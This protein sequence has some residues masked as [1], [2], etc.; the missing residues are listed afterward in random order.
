M[1]LPVLV[2]DEN[3]PLYI[4]FD[5]YFC[6][7]LYR[8]GK[9]RINSQR[10]PRFPLDPSFFVSYRC[11]WWFKRPS[12]QIITGLLMVF[13]QDYWWSITGLLMVY[14][15]CWW[16]FS[17]RCWWWFIIGFWL[18]LSISIVWSFKLIFGI[19]FSRVSFVAV[20][21]YVVS[22]SPPRHKPFFHASLQ[23]LNYYILSKR[24]MS[25]I[26]RNELLS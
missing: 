15:R 10:K 16:W 20:D 13:I 5:Y 25:H 2:N 18:F 4:L 12:V 23:T 17:Y 6:F 1:F 22:S 19:Y 11:W 8:F 21:H 14:Y 26:M 24:E 9:K 3:P 7:L